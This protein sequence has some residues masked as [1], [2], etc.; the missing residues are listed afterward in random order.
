[1][2]SPL[3]SL[4]MFRKPATVLLWVLGSPGCTEPAIQGTLT[5][6][7]KPGFFVTGI[8]DREHQPRTCKEVRDAFMHDRSAHV[9][10]VARRG[11]RWE[12]EYRP[13]VLRSC[14][15]HPESALDDPDLKAVIVEHSR[16]CSYVLRSHR[17]NT[18]QEAP[19]QLSGIGPND[20]EEIV[21]GDTAICGFFHVEPLPDL[22]PYRSA[23]IAFE[24]TDRPGERSV[25]VRDREGRWGG[26][27]VF[28]FP[29]R[30]L[31]F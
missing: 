16:S 15:E 13:A 31:I 17:S 5:S 25:V 6:A 23:M 4:G 8:A 26:D 12:L 7:P 24:R 2:V 1:M 22:V 10:V 9:S 11:M 29:S 28:H 18:Q 20:I 30:K 14:M 27:L 21:N 3:A 19:F